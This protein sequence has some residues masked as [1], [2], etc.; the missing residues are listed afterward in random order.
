MVAANR[1]TVADSTME[2]LPI[3][4]ASGYFDRKQKLR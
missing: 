4:I 3:G 2:W 1:G